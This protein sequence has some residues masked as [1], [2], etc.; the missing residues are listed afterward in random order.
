MSRVIDELVEDALREL[1]DE[2]AQRE[3]WLAADGPR[4][5]SF[6]ECISRLWD[7]SGLSEALDS[8]SGPVYTPE[9]DDRL[10]ALRRLLRRIDERRAP[11]EILHDPQLEESRAIA[12]RLLMD[13]RQFGRHRA[14]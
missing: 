10:S 12:Q 4:V 13:L 6:T 9:V 7:D 1:A 14:D 8:E 11:E 5:S 2:S 3:L